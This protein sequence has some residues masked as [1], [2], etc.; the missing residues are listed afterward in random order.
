MTSVAPLT[1][2]LTNTG[3][4]ASTSKPVVDGR[5]PVSDRLALLP[6]LS[7]IALVPSEIAPI[8]TPSASLSPA[9]TV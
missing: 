7:R 9:C 1:L 4:T 5:W 6:E 3:A 8:A 2:A